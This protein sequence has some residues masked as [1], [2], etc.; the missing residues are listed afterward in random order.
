MVRTYTKL[1]CLEIGTFSLTRNDDRHSANFLNAKENDLY[2]M[3]FKVHASKKNIVY[4]W[5]NLYNKENKVFSRNKIEINFDNVKR[6]NI[7]KY[8]LTSSIL[9]VELKKPPHVFAGLQQYDLKKKKDH[10]LNG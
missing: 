3:S 1:K 6:I 9:M 2:E 10:H 8:G 5:S 4:E 7:V